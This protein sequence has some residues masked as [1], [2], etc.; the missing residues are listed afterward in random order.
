MH[1]SEFRVFVSSSFDKS[2]LTDEHNWFV[3]AHRYNGV[4]LG[5]INP[6]SGTIW[7]D[8]VSCNGTETDIV[9]CPHNAWGSHDCGHDE[10]V[11]VRCTG[12]STTGISSRRFDTLM[13]ENIV[14]PFAC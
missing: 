10:D 1:F 8:E 4:S 5:N 6:G 9:F 7:L 13:S 12:P 2:V 3:F 14:P 11:S